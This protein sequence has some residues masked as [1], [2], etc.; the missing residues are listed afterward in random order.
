[1]TF[2]LL[3]CAWESGNIRGLR[4]S[5]STFSFIFMSRQEIVRLLGA[6]RRV[7]DD[8]IADVTQQSADDL[9]DGVSSS[10][11]HIRL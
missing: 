9:I 2:T 5:D 4:R 1:M 7:S 8:M 3:I 11:K 6:N 10:R